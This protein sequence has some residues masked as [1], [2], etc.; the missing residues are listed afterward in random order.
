MIKILIISKMD[1][2]NQT[3]IHNIDFNEIINIISQYNNNEANINMNNIDI[4]DNQIVFNL[5]SYI[6]QNNTLEQILSNIQNITHVINESS[7]SN[8]SVYIDVEIVQDDLDRDYFICCREINDKLGKSQKIKK[9][10]EVIDQC[11]LICMD[12]FKIRELKRILP[13]CKH[14]YHK[15]CIDKWLMQSASCPVCR[16][17]LM[18]GL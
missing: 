15:K 5:S 8:S 3:T 2:N 1:S 12:N 7:S 16:D 18:E 11:C 10:D 17:N 13:K 9:D 14:C 4:N 6:D